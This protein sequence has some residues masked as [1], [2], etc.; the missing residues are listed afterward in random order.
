MI[1]EQGLQSKL[2]P[3]VTGYP[4]S[5]NSPILRMDLS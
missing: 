3:Y 4:E 2:K 5:I 1:R